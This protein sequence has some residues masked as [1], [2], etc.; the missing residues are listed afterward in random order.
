MVGYG[1]IYG[2]F[3]G[4]IP[5]TW[6]LFFFS[7]N[8]AMWCNFVTYQQQISERYLYLANIGMMYALASVIIHYPL[9]I[10]VFITG[11]LVRLWYMMEMYLNDYWA[12]EYSIIE[13]KSMHYMWLMRGV[14]KF[15]VK[16]YMGALMDFNEALLYKP[17]D[18]KIL[19][20]LA[21]TTFILGD[22]V[23]AKEYLVKAKENICLPPDGLSW[24]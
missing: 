6:G 16:D 20:N 4:W 22:I 8:I 19:F 12:V 11:Y 24:A 7:V 9:V 3:N 18:L 5:L 23:K 21:T 17:Y 13:C 2:M 14:K 10:T 15:M 1:S